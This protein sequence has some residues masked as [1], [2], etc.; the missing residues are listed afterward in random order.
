MN[1]TSRNTA[2]G[3]SRKMSAAVR[4]SCFR[5]LLHSRGCLFSSAISHRVNALRL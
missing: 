3:T 1:G 2:T 5:S 4:V